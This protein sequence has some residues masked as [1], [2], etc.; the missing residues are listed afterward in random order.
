M[1]IV[2][3][4]AAFAFL[5]GSA[6]ADPQVKIEQGAL[7][8]AVDGGISV[9]RDIPFAAPPVGDLRWRSP[10]PA[11]AWTGTRD[12][13]LFGPVCPQAL[14]TD[15]K[16]VPEK[17]TE[18]EDCLT[19]NVWTPN[20]G[21]KLPVMVWIYGGSFR[22]G[23]SAFSIYDGMELAQH[24]VVVVTFNY[25]LGWLG[26]L[27][28][29]SLAAEHSGEPH[30]NYGLMDQVAALKWVQKNIASFGGDPSNVTIFGESAGG[31]SVND[32]MVSPLARGLFDK[33]ISES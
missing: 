8:G 3:L 1:R 26:F 19:A 4:A 7:S 5:A 6:L 11:P 17:H 29:P 13:T 9:F 18:N 25:R 16:P 31:M 20:T 14:R 28:M 30:G 24:G 15:G 27:D 21:G 23:G 32:L 2:A 10:Q 22:Q 12:A 33:A